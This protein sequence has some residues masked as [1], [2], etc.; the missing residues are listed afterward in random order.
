MKF[1]IVII[2]TRGGRVL[3]ISEN[4]LLCYDGR[5]F[6]GRKKGLDD[7][8]L[9]NCNVTGNTEFATFAA[10][11]R[12][13]IGPSRRVVFL[14]RSVSGNASRRDGNV[15]KTF[16]TA[17][18]DSDSHKHAQIMYRLSKQIGGTHYARVNTE[19]NY[20]LKPLKGETD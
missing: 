14:L 5:R 7:E 1:E 19:C 11:S 8:R 18:N 20:L 9:S 17:K 15:K 10:D 13:N 6:P 3:S 12:H 4:G 2:N 16:S